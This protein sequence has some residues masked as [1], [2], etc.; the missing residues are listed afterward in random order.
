[1]K[2]S[3]SP[4]EKITLNLYMCIYTQIYMHIALLEVIVKE[5]TVY[6]WCGEGNK[7]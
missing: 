5:M 2:S 6:R 3:A 4:D 1:M 7:G